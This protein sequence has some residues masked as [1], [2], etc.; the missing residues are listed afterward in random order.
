M[1]EICDEARRPAGQDP[2]V[3]GLGVRFCLPF[4]LGARP[5]PV[6]DPPLVCIA[7]VGVFPF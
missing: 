3:V 4:W 7:N 1:W 6:F 5:T 2:D